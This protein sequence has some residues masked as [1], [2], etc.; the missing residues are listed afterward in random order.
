M[1]GLEEGERPNGNSSCA[2]PR[3]AKALKFCM[4]TNSDPLFHLVKSDP[5]FGNVLIPFK[6]KVRCSDPRTKE[7]NAK[8][9]KQGVIFRVTSLSHSEVLEKKVTSSDCDRWWFIQELL[10]EFGIRVVVLRSWFALCLERLS[11]VENKAH[12]SFPS[13]YAQWIQSAR[14]EGLWQENKKTILLTHLCI[15]VRSA[16]ISQAYGSCGGEYFSQLD[17][18]VFQSR[19]TSILKESQ[20]QCYCVIFSA[21]L[22]LWK[23]I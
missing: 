22:S 4:G 6:M 15:A 1:T 8:Q 11:G 3:V 2:L 17:K 19:E 7:G 20:E 13:I 23:K 18:S 16:S 9:Y 14:C 5:F 12:W 21:F 10:H